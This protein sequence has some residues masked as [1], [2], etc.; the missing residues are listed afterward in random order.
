MQAYGHVS[1]R[2][3]V[4][5]ER[6]WLSKS[7]PPAFVTADHILEFDLD[8]RPVKPGAPKLYEERAIHGEI[9]R[10]RPDAMCVIHNHC[11]SLIPFCNTGVK[12][13]PMVG[14]AGFIGHGPPVFDIRA[15]DDSGDMNVC[16]AEQGRG[17]AKSLGAAPLCLMR[18]HGV[19]VVGESIREAV[20][21]AIIAD[22]NARL[23]MQ[24]MALGPVKFLTEAEIAWAGSRKSRDS[25]RAWT[26]WKKRAFENA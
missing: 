18:G 7:G 26:L 24:A 11:E 3:P 12:L 10:A 25:D 20:R 2:D 22:T 1:A 9:Y 21:R 5:S 19:V 16:T 14:N 15:V 6:Y 13:R 8:S 23:Q 4:N 17:L